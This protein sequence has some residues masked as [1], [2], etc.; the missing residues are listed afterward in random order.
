MARTCICGCAR[1]LVK[2][3]GRTDYDRMFFD[4]TCLAKDRRDKLREQRAHSKERRRC[5]SCRQ[6]VLDS[7]TWKQLRRLAAE[8]GID[9]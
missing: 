6:V 3:N 5:S 1:K 4:K 9:L 2:E 8:A 7:D